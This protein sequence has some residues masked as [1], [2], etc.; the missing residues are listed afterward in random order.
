MRKNKCAVQ[1]GSKGGRACV[2]Q[3]K[4]IHSPSYKRKNQSTKKKKAKKRK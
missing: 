2:D 4:G 1:L 3:Q